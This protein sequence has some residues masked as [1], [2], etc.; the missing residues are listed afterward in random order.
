MGNSTRKVRQSSPFS[1]LAIRNSTEQVSDHLS[2]GGVSS[3]V[4]RY[5]MGTTLGQT[6]VP[7]DEICL[8][9]E[10][11]TNL[12]YGHKVSSWVLSLNDH[13]I[14]YRNKCERIVFAS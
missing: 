5:S 8:I 6:A 2:S 12:L 4:Y 10:Q 7:F 1:N 11:I 9:K 13:S 14:P 3:L